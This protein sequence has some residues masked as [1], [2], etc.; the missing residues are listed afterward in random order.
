MY[1]YTLTQQ[2]IVTFCAVIDLGEHFDIFRGTE[3]CLIGTVINGPME[4]CLTSHVVTS[5]IE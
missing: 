4:S 5:Y 1:E 2:V 3:N